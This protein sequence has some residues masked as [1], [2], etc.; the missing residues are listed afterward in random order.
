MTPK[1]VIAT[2]VSGLPATPRTQMTAPRIASTTTTAAVSDNVNGATA[3]RARTL[4][5]LPAPAPSVW[6]ESKRAFATP[7]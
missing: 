4:T 6:D 2:D 3:I 1:I 7:M 5:T